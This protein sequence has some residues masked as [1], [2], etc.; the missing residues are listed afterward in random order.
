M[1]DAL[2]KKTSRR[3]GLRTSY[4][5][6]VGNGKKVLESSNPSTSKF[7]AEFWQISNKNS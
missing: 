7:L 3:K 6:A 4:S 1:S 5:N 2:K